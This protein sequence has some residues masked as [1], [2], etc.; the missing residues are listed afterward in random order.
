MN[1]LNAI[2]HDSCQ[3]SAYLYQLTIVYWS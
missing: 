3:M 2:S 1:Y